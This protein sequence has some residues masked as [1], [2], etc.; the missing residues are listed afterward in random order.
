MKWCLNYKYIGNY[1]RSGRRL[2]EWTDKEKIYYLDFYYKAEK[3]QEAITA[4]R[5]AEERLKPT[6]RPR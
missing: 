2:R 5:M 3:D 4:A 6:L 1:N